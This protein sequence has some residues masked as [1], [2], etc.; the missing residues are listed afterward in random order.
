MKTKILL[1][2]SKNNYPAPQPCLDVIGQGL[3]YIA[4]SLKASGYEVF[5]ATLNYTWCH[6]GAPLAL[7][8]MLHDALDS[9]SPDLIGISG[10]S[11]D[12]QFVRDAI[13]FIRQIAPDIKIVL[14]G[15]II[16]YDDDYIFNT[17]KPDYALV[18]DAEESFLMLIKAIETGSSL[19]DIPNLLFWEDKNSV[20]TE[21][22]QM[23]W[24][25]DLLPYPYYE[26]FQIDQSFSLMNQSDNFIFAHTVK[27]PRILP[28]TMGRSCPF[29]C[30]FCCHHKNQ[31][32][33]SR[34]INSAMDEILFFYEKY[35]FNLLFV[36]D[37]LFSLKKERI[38]EFC[39][40]INRIKTDHGINFQ[41]TSVLRVNGVDEDILDEMKKTGCIFIGYGI[42]SGSQTVLE[43]MNKKTTVSEI[44]RVIRLT[45]NAGIGVQGN[46]IIGDVAE[47]QDTLDETIDLF[48]RYK[49]LMLHFGYV[50]PYPGS[51]IFQHCLEKGIIQDKSVYYDCI[52]QIGNRMV[53]MTGMT[54]EE[55]NRKAAPLLGSEYKDLRLSKAGS[56]VPKGPCLADQQAPI[57]IRRTNFLVSVTCPFCSYENQY[58]YPLRSDLIDASPTFPH[59]CGSC[60]KRY[61]V[62]LSSFV[63]LVFH[64]DPV[65]SDYTF[66]GPNVNRKLESYKGY[67]LIPHQCK[68]FAVPHDLGA[69]NPLIPSDMRRPGII[70]A[71][72]PHDARNEIDKWKNA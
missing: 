20:A 49:D 16:S 67:N 57:E 69:V 24:E 72:D 33:R 14:G 59:Y 68:I 18:G 23:S 30:T 38:Q 3:P 27:N 26:P 53:N 2:P 28:I 11:A 62:D 66:H 12:Y 7:E 65:L 47:T 32:Y 63:P 64:E 48:N 10:L 71:T 42:E 52:S 17:L 35:Q 44:D 15:G 50:T 1:I 56:C 34:S 21:R 55:F 58:L 40:G 5:G 19:N 6:G 29:N 22:K 13:L 45:E 39:K 36:Y 61:S 54:D 46:F 4:G 43:S 31:S 41:W 37:E 51:R 8:K 25:L 9:Y 70:V 60:H